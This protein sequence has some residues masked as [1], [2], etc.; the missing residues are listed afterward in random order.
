[1]GGQVGA[2]FIASCPLS[3]KET[4]IKL[5][6]ILSHRASFKLDPSPR[7]GSRYCEKCTEGHVQPTDSAEPA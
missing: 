5:L 7:R 2:V 1:M 4:I 6:I 3:I